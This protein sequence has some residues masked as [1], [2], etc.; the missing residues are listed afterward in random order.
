MFERNAPHGLLADID[1]GAGDFQHELDIYGYESVV[2]KLYKA[3][4]SLCL[5]RPKPTNGTNPS[6]ARVLAPDDDSNEFGLLIWRC[7]EPNA[8][9]IREAEREMLVRERGRLR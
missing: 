2:A 5:L 4:G 3:H 6:V 8:D 7:M 1:A 9:I